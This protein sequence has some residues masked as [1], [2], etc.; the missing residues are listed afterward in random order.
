MFMYQ[1]IGEVQSVQDCQ[2]FCKEI[3]AGN[4]TYFLYDRR[5][6]ECKMFDGSLVDF[7]TDC[8][9]VGYANVPDHAQCDTLFALDSGN[10]CYVSF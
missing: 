10:G 4:C 8:N 5:S 2:W 7:Q 3:Y 6:E 1:E 9:E